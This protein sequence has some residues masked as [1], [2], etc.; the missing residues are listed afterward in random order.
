MAILTIDET[1]CKQDG[2]CAAECPRRIITQVDD[3]SYPQIAEADE[4]YCMVCGHCVAVCP[5]GALDHA[6]MT[7]DDCLPVREE[8][9][10]SPEQVVHF[11]R[12]RRS[13][14]AYKKKDVPRGKVTKL[15]DVA[16]F[17]ALTGV[18]LE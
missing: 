1:K 14:R 7:A 8:Y 10:V 3:A 12:A 6:S 18:H 11:L 13:I 16:R 15:I 4:A 5:H 9:L 17:V 2:I